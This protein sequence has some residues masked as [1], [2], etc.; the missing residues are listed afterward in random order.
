MGEFHVKHVYTSAPD[1][2]E[3]MF[4]ENQANGGNCLFHVEQTV[5]RRRRCE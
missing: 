1:C 3:G 4:H 5:L 2:E